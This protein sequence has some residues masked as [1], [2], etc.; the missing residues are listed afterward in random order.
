MS[1][2]QQLVQIL[3]VSG[4]LLAFGIA[5]WLQGR[6]FPREATREDN[7]LDI[8]MTV[9]MP[10]IAGAVM[11]LSLAACRRWLPGWQDA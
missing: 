5:E 11:T 7:R 4:V 8:A 1:G 2:E 3:A 6:F 10:L 9:L